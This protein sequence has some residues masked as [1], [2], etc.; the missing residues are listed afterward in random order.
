M[1]AFGYVD[2]SDAETPSSLSEVTLLV[3][4]DEIQDLIDFLKDVKEEHSKVNTRG[5]VNHSHLKD[6]KSVYKET[7]LIIA[8]K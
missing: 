8:T 4:L 7:D 2:N 6:W 5:V 1:K 3:T